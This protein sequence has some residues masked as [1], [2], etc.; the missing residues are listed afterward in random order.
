MPW[1]WNIWA[2]SLEPDIAE[3]E[4]ES[5]KVPEGGH[6]QARESPVVSQGTDDDEAARSPLP[7]QPSFFDTLADQ[8][9]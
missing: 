5:G 4:A 7:K 1:T 3:M 8:L 9:V 2:T 6:K